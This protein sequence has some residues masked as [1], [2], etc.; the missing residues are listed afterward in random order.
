[1]GIKKV[2]SLVVLLVFSIM[3]SLTNIQVFAQTSSESLIKS[4]VIENGLTKDD[5]YIEVVLNVNDPENYIVDS[6]LLVSIEELTYAPNRKFFQ[7][8]VKN[9]SDKEIKD[10][11]IVTKKIYISSTITISRGVYTGE[12]KNGKA[13]GYGKVFYTGETGWC[14]GYWVNDEPNGYCKADRDDTKIEGNLINGY[15]NGYGKLSIRDDKTKT[16]TEY[17][18][19][20]KNGIMNGYFLVTSSSYKMLATFKDNV[21]QGTACIISNDGTSKNFEYKDGEVVGD[22]KEVKPNTKLETATDITNYLNENYGELKT[23]LGTTKFT[24][25]VLKNDSKMFDYDFTIQT[26]YD[27]QFFWYDLN[28]VGVNTSDKEKVKIELKDFQEK[29]GKDIIAK[30]PDK[31]ING[32]YIKMWW[33]YPNIRQDLITQNYYTWKNYGESDFFNKTP[34]YEQTKAGEFRWTPTLDD[35]WM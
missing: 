32:G 21:I 10:S 18:G 11:I 9:K 8:I 23:T 33:R 34:R 13:N 16:Y 24:Y 15:L 29:L 3:I 17:M 1:M 35:N 6:V 4:I 27:T 28:K 25:T 2:K 19:N 14:E 20:F 31:K 12:V 7:G 22:K 30:L 26:N 5:K